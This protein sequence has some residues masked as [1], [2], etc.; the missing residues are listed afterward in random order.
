M[1]YFIPD[2]DE[3]LEELLL[4]K[5]MPNDYV[6]ADIK[7]INEA[8]EEVE[9]NG[10]YANGNVLLLVDLEETEER[11]INFLDDRN[12]T[13]KTETG[14]YVKKYQ[15]KEE[16]TW[17]WLVVNGRSDKKGEL[18]AAEIPVK[19]LSISMPQNFVGIAFPDKYKEK[20]MEIIGYSGIEVFEYETGLEQV[21]F[22]S[23]KL[24]VNVTVD[25]WSGSNKSGF[26]SAARDILATVVKKDIR[27][28]VPH[29]NAQKPKDNGAF[30]ILI[31][32]SPDEAADNNGFV[33][34]EMWGIEVDYRSN[35][36]EPTGMGQVIFDEAGSAVGELLKDNL[37]IFHDICENGTNREI[38]IFKKIL[39][40]TVFYLTAVP[41]EIEKRIAKFKALIRER[42]KKTYIDACINRV[43]KMADGAENKVRS[44]QNK[45]DQ[46]QREL[47]KTIQEIDFEKKHRDMITG[48]LKLNEEHFSQEFEDIINIAGIEDIR[49][50]KSLI[51]FFTEFIN[52]EHDGEVYKIGKFK[53]D[54]CTD[55]SRSL[56][57]FLNLTNRG[58]GPSSDVRKREEMSEGDVNV[59]YNWHHPHIDREG[60][61]CLGNIEEAIARYIGEQQ[62]DIAAIVLLKYLRSVN[63][64]DRA[65]AGIK[66]WPKV[67]KEEMANV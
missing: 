3:V 30:N 29:G 17:K 40:E 10:L 34:E 39:S 46:Y 7:T 23:D 57:K 5:N 22:L 26:I 64:E 18:E 43:K 20:A 62:Y 48:M 32:S 45:I 8:G 1:R 11:L 58:M 47:V 14:I 67:E 31:W 59:S 56:V 16:L 33:P 42:T 65:G 25:Y 66:W 54:I 12:E 60:K 49:A 6:Y 38:E 55:G 53:I 28:S 61:G 24:I 41:E 15:I 36:F 37:Y 63:T 21:L 44:L 35:G 27:I 51:S 19:E 13:I 52:I 9:I 4:R 2:E 50:Q